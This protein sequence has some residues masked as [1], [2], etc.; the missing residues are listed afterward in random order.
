MFALSLNVKQFYL[1]YR[2]DPIRCYHSRPEWTWEQCQWRDTPHSLKLQHYSPS[3]CLMSY[4][5]HS[6]RGHFTLCRDA[7]GVFYP[8]QPTWLYICYILIHCSLIFFRFQ[9]CL[10]S[11]VLC[12]HLLL[13]NDIER[14]TFSHQPQ[15]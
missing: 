12:L 5:G 6:L 9:R 1:T 4:Q 10:E 15:N 8:H 2:E 14:L 13:L 11:R 7:V 3:D